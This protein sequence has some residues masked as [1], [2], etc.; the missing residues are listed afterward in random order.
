MK[1]I[2]YWKQQ[3]QQ[4]D[5]QEPAEPGDALRKGFKK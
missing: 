3:L 4:L 1:F 5:V 2:I